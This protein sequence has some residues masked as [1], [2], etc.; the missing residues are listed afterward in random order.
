MEVT[1]RGEV[2]VR[3]ASIKASSNA[4]EFPDPKYQLIKSF[5]T[6]VNDVIS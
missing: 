5:L 3:S 2:Y 4:I 1:V 6:S